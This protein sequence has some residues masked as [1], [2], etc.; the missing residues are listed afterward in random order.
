MPSA[1]PRSSALVPLASSASVVNVSSALRLAES[2]GVERLPPVHV[3]LLV[4]VVLIDTSLQSWTCVCADE[5]KFRAWVPLSA[6]AAEQGAG[7]GVE[8]QL[9]WATWLATAAFQMDCHW[10]A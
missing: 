7:V 3:E 5:P 6:E 10:A 2:A 4:D 8:L 1:V 9:S